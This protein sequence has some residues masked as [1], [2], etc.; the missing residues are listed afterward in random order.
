MSLQIKVEM[1]FRALE[2]LEKIPQMLQFAVADKVM[3]AMVKPVV[4]RAKELAPSSRESGTRKKW[5]AKYKSNNKWQVDSGRHMGSKTV[6]YD[7]GA[8]V[9]V[10]AKYPTGNKQ[11]FNSNSEKGRKEVLWGRSTGRV[12]KPKERFIQRAYDETRDAQFRAFEAELQRQ[13]KEL[14]IG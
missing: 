9:Y 3:L 4:D 10:G 2:M 12:Y 14:R 5:S 7:R 8:I 13:V 1:D 11:Q 6:R